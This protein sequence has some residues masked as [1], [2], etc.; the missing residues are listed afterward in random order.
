MRLVTG[1]LMIERESVPVSGYEIHMGISQGA[2]LSRP[3]VR[4]KEGQDGALSAD[5]QVAGTY[6]HG[7]FETRSA[8]NAL[9]A[10]AGLEQVQTPDYYQLREAGIDRLADAA[11]ASL[12][13][14]KI[15]RIAAG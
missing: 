15:I 10:W 14:D 4:L 3:L 8:C 5:N 12:D 6:L 9:L 11:E 1:E 13:M 7:L 2:A